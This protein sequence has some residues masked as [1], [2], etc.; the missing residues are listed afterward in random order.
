[1]D[2]KGAALRGGDSG[3]GSDVT[4]GTVL[5]V[6]FQAKC[7]NQN[8]P[9][10]HIRTVPLVTSPAAHCCALDIR[11]FSVTRCNMKVTAQH[12]SVSGRNIQE[13]L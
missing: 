8:R 10:C 4:V 9:H 1:M 3:D 13:G 5:I 7:D 12:S 6:T 2:V 11:T